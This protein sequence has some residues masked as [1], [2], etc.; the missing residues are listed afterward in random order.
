MM[1]YPGKRISI[2]IFYLA[3]NETIVVPLKD[4]DKLLVQYQD[5]IAG[6]ENGDFHAETDARRCPNC[7]AYFMC[8]GNVA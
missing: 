5:A 2:E 6:I 7:P 1:T 3:T 8:I 4:D